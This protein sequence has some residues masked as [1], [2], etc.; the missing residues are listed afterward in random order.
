MQAYLYWEQS[1]KKLA[2]PS[3]RDCVPFRVNF[4]KNETDWLSMTLIFSI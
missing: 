4:N 3:L 1:I 2:L